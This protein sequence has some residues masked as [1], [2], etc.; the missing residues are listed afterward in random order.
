MSHVNINSSTTAFLRQQLSINIE[1]FFWEGG[2]PQIQSRPI[3]LLSKK[4]LELGG[5]VGS[6]AILSAHIVTSILWMHIVGALSQWLV[7]WLLGP[8]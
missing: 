4:L 3:A 8:I 7:R 1:S 6:R 5:T 2:G